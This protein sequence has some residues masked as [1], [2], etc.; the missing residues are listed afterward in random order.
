MNESKDI[1]PIKEGDEAYSKSQNITK[2]KLQRFMPKGTSTKV[3]DD[4]VEIIHSI[5]NDTGLAQEVA[6]ERLLGTMHLLGKQ[7][8]TLEKLIN[9]VKFCS[10]KKHMS[11]KRAWEI[12]FPDEYDRIVNSGREVDS[13]VSMYN[14]TYLVVEIDKMMLVPFHIM[15]DKYKHEA[16][17]TQ[18]NLMRGI[19]ANHDD[20]VTPHIQHLAS[21]TVYEMLRGPEDRSFELKVGAS[22]ALVAQNREMLEGIQEIV[23]MQAEGFKNGGKAKDIQ[24]IHF[25]KSKEEEEIVEADYE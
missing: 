17:E 7:G 25:K 24:K 14:S 15:Y 3:T 16:L 10:L 20:R 18:V 12:V 1:K 19:G 22:D 13:H 23:R 2:E 21:K 4:I 8:V 9:A 11:N 6:E 5:E